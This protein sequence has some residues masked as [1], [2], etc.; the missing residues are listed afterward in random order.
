MSI[1]YFSFALSVIFVALG[2]AELFKDG[3]KVVQ[4]FMVAASLSIVA[5]TA[6][7]LFG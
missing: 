5:T 1:A 3:N 4:F 2:L 6:K 7:Y